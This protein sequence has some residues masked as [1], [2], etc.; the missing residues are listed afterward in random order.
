MEAFYAALGVCEVAGRSAWALSRNGSS[1]CCRGLGARWR[2]YSARLPLRQPWWAIAK[3]AGKEVQEDNLTDWAAALTFYAV[4]SLFPA[5]LVL[6]ALVAEVGRL[7]R[8][9]R[10]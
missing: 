7:Y 2:T 8:T 6:V 3:R 5:L 9:L 10:H 1:S 4:L